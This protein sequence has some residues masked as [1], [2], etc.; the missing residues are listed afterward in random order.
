M[1]RISDLTEA[2]RDKL[3]V[4]EFIELWQADPVASKPLSMGERWLLE[5]EDIEQEA[6]QQEKVAKQKPIEESSET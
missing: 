5:A 3:S 6:Q 2:E 4:E 1:V